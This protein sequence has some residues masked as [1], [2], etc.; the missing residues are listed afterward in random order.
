MRAEVEL[1]P[2]VGFGHA[3]YDLPAHLES[4]ARQA[5][6]HGDGV[7]PDVLLGLRLELVELGTHRGETGRRPDLEIDAVWISR[8]PLLM[9]RSTIGG[10]AS[11][12]AMNRVKTSI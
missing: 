5:F 10:G 11:A 6:T 2:N 1:K 12:L 7:E 8:A 4:S 3:W 9:V